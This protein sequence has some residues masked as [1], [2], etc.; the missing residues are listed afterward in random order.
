MS[1]LDYNMLFY[2]TDLFGIPQLRLSLLLQICSKTLSAKGK[3]SVGKLPGV[4]L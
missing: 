2:I 1:K 4:T 3:Q